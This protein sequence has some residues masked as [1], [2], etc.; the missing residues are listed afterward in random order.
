MKASAVAE[1][2]PVISSITPRSHVTS[3]T[4]GKGEKSQCDKNI[5]LGCQ[6][7]VPNMDAS[8]MVVVKNICRWRLKDSCEKKNCSIT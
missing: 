7:K 6:I 5:D 4:K 2:P 1:T 8:K 3:A